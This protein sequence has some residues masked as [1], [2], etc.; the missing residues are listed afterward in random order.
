MYL[1]T[2]QTRH[3]YSLQIAKMQSKMSVWALD[4]QNL[5]ECSWGLLSTHAGTRGLHTHQHTGHGHWFPRTL[6]Q[7]QVPKLLGA[8]WAFKLYSFCRKH[9]HWLI[10][11]LVPWPR[12]TAVPHGSGC[13]NDCYSS[14]HGNVHLSRC[15]GEKITYFPQWSAIHMDF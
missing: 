2:C 1:D 14:P 11:I 6:C 7:P 15:G 5:D 12:L 13:D 3:K 8:D 9:C 4:W 10:K